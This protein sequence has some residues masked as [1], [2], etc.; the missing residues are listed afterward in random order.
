[1]ESPA[2]RSAV[3]QQ[4]C[5]GI[6]RLLQPVSITAFSQ[7]QDAAGRL[8]SVKLCDRISNGDSEEA[9]RCLCMELESDL[10]F[11]VLV[12]TREEWE[13]L[14]SSPSSFA[15]RIRETG[16]VLYEKN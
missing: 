9:E 1:M 6:V 13:D 11:D 12:Y 10:P 8:Q 4:L 14:L 5:E 3:L 7:K 15:C 16:S 2:D